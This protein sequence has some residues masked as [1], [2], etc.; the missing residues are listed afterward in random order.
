M[1]DY[2]AIVPRLNGPL[3]PILSAFDDQQRLDTESV[4]QWVESLIDRGIKHFWTTHGTTHFMCLAD[5][6]IVELTRCVASVTRGRSIFIASTAYH[7]P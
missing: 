2:K 4:T 5:D 3:V 7:W 1:S 6:E